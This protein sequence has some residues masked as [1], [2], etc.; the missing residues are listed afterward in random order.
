M[1]FAPDQDTRDLTIPAEW[2]T[3]VQDTGTEYD[4]QIDIV[5]DPALDEPQTYADGDRL[6]VLIRDDLSAGRQL[7]QVAHAVAAYTR[8]NPESGADHRVCIVLAVQDE[9]ELLALVKTQS[10]YGGYLWVETGY[11]PEPESTALA[12]VSDGAD[13]RHLPLAGGTPRS[14]TS[15]TPV[16]QNNHSSDAIIKALDLLRE[17]GKS[18]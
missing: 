12:V 18:L 16:A 6:Y 2:Y 14:S 15:S 17:I 1:T 11:G 7:A 13:F 9:E 3:P 4:L 10:A 5:R 8:W